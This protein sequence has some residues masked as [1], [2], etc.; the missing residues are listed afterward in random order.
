MTS[1]QN[2]KK[3]W[4]ATTKESMELLFSFN[5]ESL[6]KQ[7]KASFLSKPD[8]RALLEIFKINFEFL[9]DSFFE[10]DMFFYEIPTPLKIEETI[11]T[12]YQSKRKASIGPKFILK[13]NKSVSQFS[14]K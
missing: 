4:H 12:K 7:H 6:I 2:R 13:K 8:Q 3:K 11:H 5:V 10:D 14:K 1:V 9:F